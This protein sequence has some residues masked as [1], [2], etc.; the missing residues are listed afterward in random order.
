MMR[1]QT[2]VDQLRV[3]GVVIMR[4]GLDAGIGQVVDFDLEAHV[5]AGGLH[6]VREIENGDL[7]EDSEFAG[8][9]RMRTGDLDTADRVANVEEAARLPALAVHGKG[10]A[11]RR[12]RAESVQHRAENF[13]V[14]EAVDERF[15]ER[16][17]IRHRAVDDPLIQIRG[18]QLP[19]AAAEHD[20]VAVVH[21][22]EVVE[23]AGLLRKRQ[24]VLAAVVLDFDV[25]LFNVDI[26]RTVL[27]HRPELHQVAVVV[28]FAQREQ[29]VQRADHVIY[30]R[31][32]GVAPVN[33]RIRSG[34][35]LGEVD[36]GFGLEFVERFGEELVVGHVTDEQVDL[37]AGVFVPGA[38]TIRKRLDRR[39][40]LYAQLEVPLPADEVVDDRD[41]VALLGQIQRCRPTAVAISPQHG[42]SHEASYRYLKLF[43]GLPR[44]LPAYDCSVLLRAAKARKRLF[45]SESYR[46][47]RVRTD[48][49][50]K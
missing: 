14:V 50:R 29:Q 8:R 1:L 13:V 40:R 3:L 2:Q 10:M 45:P 43:L 31:E 7:I 19:R 25:A 47:M 35:L 27:A 48:Q 46:I 39:E 23:R 22:R 26:R 20:V 18:A 32:R 17:F 30:L 12:L 34:A 42:N 24:Y 9:G 6:F 28:E 4:F 44:L 15:I 5:L 11:H 37:L 16:S 49:N 41:G 21:L 36:P 33:H 38:E